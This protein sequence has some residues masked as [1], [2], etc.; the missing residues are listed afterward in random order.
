METEPLKEYKEEEG[1]TKFVKL[2]EKE[3]GE[4]EPMSFD[5]YYQIVSRAGLIE[6]RYFGV[7]TGS[8][9]AFVWGEIVSL[10]G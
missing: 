9:G 8:L 1:F 5:N 6:V 2:I 10:P 7:T 4:L 3:Q